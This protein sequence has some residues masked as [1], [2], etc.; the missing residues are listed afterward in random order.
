MLTD[1]LAEMA[2]R[3]VKRA[4]AIVLAAYSS[5]PSCRQYREDINHAQAAVGTGAP[6]VD[7]IR[8]FFNHPEFIAAN[9]DRVH[10]AI[11]QFAGGRE[12]S[13]HVAFTAHSIPLSMAR[14]CNYEQ[15][16][17]ET[18]RLVAAATGIDP[19][20]SAVVYQSRSG[21]PE[22]PCLGPDILDHLK[23]LKIRGVESVLVHPVGF[24]SDHLEVMFD[25]DVE[26]H[27]LCDVLGLEMMR[28]RTVGTHPRFVRMLCSLAAERLGLDTARPAVG[29]DGPSHDVCPET[30]CPAPTRPPVRAGVGPGDP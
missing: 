25:L 9:A 17:R 2:A 19:E 6:M 16:I 27:D 18:C 22:D 15:Q 29:R 10:E 8:V 3:G 12:G 7:K 13:L 21:R 4:L 1:T 5:Y 23:D 14:T 26:A 24:V 28:S 11:S 30:C 20:R